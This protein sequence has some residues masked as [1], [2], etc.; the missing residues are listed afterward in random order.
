MRFQKERADIQKQQLEFLSREG[1]F[2]TDVLGRMDVVEHTDSRTRDL[3]P[4]GV[5]SGVEALRS[6][7]WA[8]T[9]LEEVFACMTI[10]DERAKAAPIISDRYD[11][12]LQTF[13]VATETVKLS[14]TVLSTHNDW[15]PFLSS[16]RK[17]L[18]LQHETIKNIKANFEL[19]AKD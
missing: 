9:S 3:S 5:R 4:R 7:L 13:D 14:E 12:V 6:M 8:M 11:T 19:N 16:L 10:K 18:G 15:G 1:Q 17:Q 2:L